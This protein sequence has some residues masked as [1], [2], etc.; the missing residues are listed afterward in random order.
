MFNIDLGSLLGPIVGALGAIAGAA[1]VF[2]SGKSS[3][4]KEV[5]AESTDQAL[6]TQIA[7]LNAIEGAPQTKTEVTTALDNPKREI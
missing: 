1:I 5:I 2:F 3:G 4:R 7:M 6:K